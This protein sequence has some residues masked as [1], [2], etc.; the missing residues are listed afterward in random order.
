VFQQRTLFSDTET[1]SSTDLKK[2]GLYKYWDD[3]NAEIILLAYAFDNDPVRV[4]DVM[5][6]ETVPQ[7]FLDALQDPTVIKR[8]FNAA[9]ERQAYAKHFGIYCDPEQWRCTMVLGM[10]LGL[11]GSLAMQAKVLKMPL[12]KLSDIGKDGIKKFC[13]PIKKPLKKH[14][15]RTRNLPHHFLEAWN[16]FKEYN[17]RDV[18]AERD[19]YCRLAK[20]DQPCLWPLWALDQR[21]NDR[22]VMID[23]ELVENAIRINDIVKAELTED[24]RRLTGLSNP[25]SVQQLIAWLNN[26]EDEEDKQRA[27]FEAD[28]ELNPDINVDAKITDLRK[29]TV[30]ELLGTVQSP[31]AKRVLQLRQLM[32][33]SSV[34]KYRA[35][36]RSVCRDGRIRG[37]L[38]F[39]GAARTGRWAGRIVQV[40]NLPQNHLP[41]LETARDL[42]KSGD[43]ETL[44][45]LFGETILQVLSELIRT[46][47][48]PAPGKRFISVDYSAIEARLT[49]WDAQEAWRLE[50]FRTHGKIYEAS[51]SKMFKVPLE[52]ITK[53][54]PLRQKGKVTEL[55]CVGPDTE[56]LTD[57]GYIPIVDVTLND[58]LW[59][60]EKWVEHAGLL[61]K[62]K[63]RVMQLDGLAVT[64][65]HLVLTGQTWRPARELAS[66]AAMRFQALAT[67]SANLPSS[68]SCAAISAA[69]TQYGSVARAAQSLM[70]YTARISYSAVRLAASNARDWLRMADTAIDAGR[71]RKDCRK[72]SIAT[73]CSS[74]FRQRF[75]VA[76]TQRTRAMQTTADA[77][78][79]YAMNGET[80]AARSWFTP[81]PFPALMT[82]LWKWTENALTGTMSRGTYGSSQSATTTRTGEKFK[83]CKPAS[84]P[85]SD[86]YDIAHAGPLNRFT[87][88]T[89]SGHM[90]VHNCGYQG[91][92]NALINMGALEGKNAMKEEELL[93]AVKLWRKESPNVVNNWYRTQ[94]NAT[95][96]IKYKKIVKEAR[97]GFE[98]RSN[99]LFQILPS[100]RRLAY[101]NTR[102]KFDEKF[103]RD[104]IVFEGIDQYTHQWK[105]QK[106]FGG[107]LFQNRTQANGVDLIGNSM[108]NIDREGVPIV[109]GVHD[110][111]VM[112]VDEAWKAAPS[113][114]NP[115]KSE[116]CVYLEELMCRPHPA[117]P[118]LPLAADGADLK[119]YQ[120]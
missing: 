107:K 19:L 49:A 64:P 17:K 103:G 55:A 81:Q 4:I 96:S 120:K 60:G 99:T 18:E 30:I 88:R 76:T 62:G 113:A 32:A 35:M 67:G 40:Q 78:S 79:V 82:R 13:V 110:E 68:V 9:F 85:W 93:P 69:F 21:I 48:I 24:A 75:S 95:E 8:A 98:Y 65:D 84:M 109:F 101:P 1:Y 47:F 42:V 51:A 52:Q 80:I 117:F 57:R 12:Q 111:N 46:A 59:D 27:Q 97:Y 119:F 118:G 25:N 105:D 92:P 31:T 22:G 116:G 77:E 44:K 70:K 53:A 41:D 28:A 73:A 100:G 72:W 5:Q 11:P 3:P 61:Y 10:S 115:K 26:A 74:G 58:K 94:D 45:L 106:T 16:G 87:V 39:Y 50:V 14:G 37:L 89:N 56:V 66:S 54:N 104:A 23:V 29:K 71:T 20:Y 112:E 6:G 108:L 33:K 83:S 2:C 34:S 7:E 90:L 102:I 91:G 114:S 86:V 36:Q 63:R 15:Y 38:Q 43:I